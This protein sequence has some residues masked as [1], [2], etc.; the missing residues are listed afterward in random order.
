M[1]QLFNRLQAEFGRVL[2]LDAI[3]DDSMI[4][5]LPWWGE[6]GKVFEIGDWDMQ[7]LERIDNVRSEVT[8]ACRL[9]QARVDGYVRDANGN[10]FPRQRA[11]EMWELEQQR[12][13]QAEANRKA[14]MEKLASHPELVDE[15]IRR[16]VL[17]VL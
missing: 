5:R 3:D 7:V 17:G 16:H 4:F 1:V 8:E 6:N 12:L 2:V 10:Y 15:L 13:R 11:R 14:V 9:V